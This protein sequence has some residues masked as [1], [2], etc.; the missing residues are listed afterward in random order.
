MN[1]I[2]NKKILTVFLFLIIISM[3]IPYIDNS[4]AELGDMWRQIDTES[5]ARNFVKY[6]FNIFYP[7]FNYDGPIPN[8]VQLEFQ[9]TTFI[10]E[11][12]YDRKI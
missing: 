1:I 10:I 3:R 2:R 6:K 8:Y 7:Q 11:V 4:P 5:I 12:C 9:I